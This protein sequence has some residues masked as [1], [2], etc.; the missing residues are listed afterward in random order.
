MIRA[1]RG[2]LTR[3]NHM[4]HSFFTRNFDDGPNTNLTPPPPTLPDQ[5]TQTRAVHKR[6]GIGGGGTAH[7][8][9]KSHQMTCGSDEAAQQR[10]G[11]VISGGSGGLEGVRAR[12]AGGAGKGGGPGRGSWRREG[13]HGLAAGGP[14]GWEGW[15]SPWLEVGLP[16]APVERPCSWDGGCRGPTWATFDGSAGQGGGGTLSFG[17]ICRSAR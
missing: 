11:G 6:R 7:R 1:P 3:Y 13:P 4:G 16:W 14:V 12:C 5:R 10:R 15:G 17:D 9:R 2:K 8:R